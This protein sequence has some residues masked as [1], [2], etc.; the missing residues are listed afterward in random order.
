M[1]LCGE[2]AEKGESVFGSL[3]RRQMLG[4]GEH[5]LPLGIEADR[6]ANL[7]PRRWNRADEREARAIARPSS[8]DENGRIENY[9]HRLD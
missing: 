3:T 1:R 2:E 8:R 9:A 4:P 5:I 6:T 7:K